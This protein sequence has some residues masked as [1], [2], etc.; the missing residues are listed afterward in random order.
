MPVEL[1]ETYP[2][3]AGTD[4]PQAGVDVGTRSRRFS[5]SSL[6]ACL[7]PRR[8]NVSQV[9]HQ[10]RWKNAGKIDA[11]CKC[12]MKKLIIK[13]RLVN[14]IVAAA[15][16]HHL[17]PIVFLS[18]LRLPHRKSVREEL[19]STNYP[20]NNHPWAAAS[21]QRKVYATPP[22][23]LIQMTAATVTQIITLKI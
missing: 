7:V 4:S 3:Y 11:K 5:F 9:S 18:V 8:S 15:C 10:N 12:I 21:L 23:H 13:V 6:L 2:A 20:S 14:A 16:S 22:P 17:I 19:P 1:R